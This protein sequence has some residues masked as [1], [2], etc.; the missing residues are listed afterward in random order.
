LFEWGCASRFHDLMLE[1]ACCATGRQALTNRLR[2][3]PGMGS[4]IRTLLI[5]LLALA[6]PTQG[7]AAATM[8]F[9][10]P[11][12]HGAGP[13]AHAQ[14]A[15]AQHAHPG[16]AVQ[17]GHTHHGANHAEHP[18]A[19]HGAHHAGAAQADEGSSSG[20]VGKAPANL[21]QADSQKCS[22]CAS[23]CSAAALPASSP[24]LAAP[25]FSA[26]VFAI[27]EPSVEPFAADG[28]ERPPR[29]VLA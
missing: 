20:D 25:D 11:N 24:S 29:I 10:G 16:S 5:W 2:Y 4:R 12:H 23:C 18:G 3:S 13:A 27:V 15:A 17:G 22:A 6:L 14:H 21:K 1:T 9:C 26:T 8:A 7:M 28:L 19:I